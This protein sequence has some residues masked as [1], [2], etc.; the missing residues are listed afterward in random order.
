MCPMWLDLCSLRAQ[1]VCVHQ[2][3][4][5]AKYCSSKKW[6]DFCPS[7]THCHSSSSIFGSPQIDPIYRETYSLRAFAHSLTTRAIQEPKAQKPMDSLPWVQ[8]DAL[9]PSSTSGPRM[10]SLWRREELEVRVP[11]PSCSFSSWE[12][13][14]VLSLPPSTF[15]ETHPRPSGVLHPCNTMQHRC[16]TMQHRCNQ[17]QHFATS[18]QHPGR[19]QNTT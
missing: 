13:G 8:A 4:S 7:L 2:C 15:T 11:Y 6:K 18:M 19:P 16:N 3:P 1:S 17:M 9:R 5:V 12:K 10:E 14:A